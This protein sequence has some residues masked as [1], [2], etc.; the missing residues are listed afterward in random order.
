VMQAKWS[1]LLCLLC[2]VGASAQTKINPVTQIN[3][4]NGY[5]FVINNYV[6]GQTPY[7]T[8]QEAINAAAATCS[9]TVSTCGSVT[10]PPGYTGTDTWTNIK[11]VIVNDQRPL[12]GAALYT[13]NTV[14]IVN[15][16]DFGAVCNGENNDTA[17]INAAL[18]SQWVYN[19][20]LTVKKNI[21]VQLPQ[22]SCLITAPLE[23]G[24]YA[25]LV[26]QDSATFLTCDYAAWVGTD[27]NCLE[28][29]ASGQISAGASIGQRRIGGFSLIGISNSGIA[30][31]T[32]ISMINSSN[33]TSPSYTFI[34]ISIDHMQIADFD[35]LIEA[36]D[37]SDSQISFVKGS[38]SR[39][40]FDFNGNVTNVQVSNTN[41]FDGSWNSTSNHTL[42]YGVIVEPNNK[43]GIGGLTCNVNVYCGP[44]GVS[45][46]HS[47]VLSY[48]T[49][50]YQV[51][52]IAC[53]YQNG[54][55]DQAAGGAYSQNV[56]PA[57]YAIQL[58]P[59][60]AGDGLFITDNN[61]GTLN[62]SGTIVYSQMNGA[63][64]WITGNYF[65]LDA[66]PSPV[67]TVGLFMLG[68]GTASQISINDNKFSNVSYGIVLNQPLT[69]SSIRGNTGGANNTLIWLSG[70]ANLVHT[71]T[72]VEDNVET[73]SLLA[74]TEGTASGMRVGWNQ[75]P[76][77][78]TGSQTLSVAGCTFAAGA[79][80]N[81]CTVS[82]NPTWP[83]PFADASYTLQCS[84]QSPNGPTTIS[85]AGI[86]N[87][88]SISV[89]EAALSTGSTGGG[90]I[91]CTGIHP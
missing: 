16:T 54:A 50:V 43:Y 30:T 29:A 72:V 57:G 39:V 42:T 59:L 3:W 36:Q 22:G 58:G 45:F 26:G 71:A 9:T 14:K 25:S 12:N 23:L 88:S 6:A 73:S 78:F 34:N 64:A 15:A 68:S 63:G 79:I 32:G 82:P 11:G 44:Q 46:Y 51:Q 62:P 28:M 76:A 52:C 61:L 17:A 10:I 4:P 5:P 40:G 75:S 37:F 21:T 48:D 18:A 27:Y 65:F 90:S 41:I 49:D 13:P 55:F 53:T 83:I 24:V 77:Q 80:G 85:N 47:S 56:A 89:T 87:G 91:V 1:W 70:A 19:L 33:I 60:A 31:S 84:V 69:Y 35:T 66:G 81:N 38:G 86:V 7:T 8:I 2:F 20:P 67:D 74:V